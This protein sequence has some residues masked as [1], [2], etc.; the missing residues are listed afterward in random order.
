M[1]DFPPQC[2]Q[3]SVCFI[4][5]HMLMRAGDTSFCLI[6]WEICSI[7]CVLMIQSTSKVAHASRTQQNQN[8]CQV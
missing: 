7:S 6:G 4:V 1:V 3:K 5:R 2:V 8:P